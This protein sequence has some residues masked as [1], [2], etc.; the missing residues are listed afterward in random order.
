MP[1]RR[2]LPRPRFLR[3]RPPTR[4][5]LGIRLP[6]LAFLAVLGPGLISGFA[7]NDAGGITTYSV[8]GAQFGYDLMWVVLASMI[9]LGITQEVGARLGLATGQGFGGLLRERFGVKGA[10]FAIGTMLLANLGDTVAE[11]AG[12]GASLALFGVPVPLSAGL[13]A[14]LVIVF[15]W[16][17]NFGR[18]QYVFLAVG[19]G[20]SLAYA[21]SAVL[22]RP[23][24][25]LAV[26]R[27]VVPHGNLSAAYLL[28]VLGTVGTTIT[29]WGQAFIQS[30][31]ADKNLGREDL[32]ATRLDIGLGAFLTNLVAAFIVV[33]CAATLW[34]HGQ[35]SINSAADAAR[36]LGP[37][38]GQFASTLFAI[39]LFT[40][41]VLGLG[42]VPLTSTYAA[43]EAFGWERGL[44][45][46][47]RQAPAFYGILAFFV[48][49]SAL[50]ILIPG[51][52][53]I[54]VMYLS[55]V[56][57]GLLLPIIL[58]YVMLMSRDR[59]LLGKMASG[60]ILQ[61]L[62]WAVTGLISL[63]S[64]ALVVSQFASRSG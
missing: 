20:T 64:V 30:Y 11:F 48:F 44:D 32:A 37:L 51:L 41:S 50:F 9:A 24:W 19:I 34:A 57:D 17:A 40:A 54:G 7:D 55:Q 12:I 13:A 26:T 63:L 45:R 25:G 10:S 8:V 4:R 46:H 15:L 28:A 58:V 33:A 14:L 35:T 18:I 3:L 23:D 36:A 53:L 27:A 47:W 59:R 39:G 29:P 61:T 31:V 60:P 42:T 22:A 6:R 16:R 2:A 43:T 62:G 5:I 1:E 21:I 56:F 52:P 49:S 38:A